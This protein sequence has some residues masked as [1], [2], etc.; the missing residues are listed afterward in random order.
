MEWV[1]YILIFLFIFLLAVFFLVL[2]LAFTFKEIRRYRIKKVKYG[3][4]PQVRYGLFGRWYYIYADISKGY[5]EIAKNIRELDKFRYAYTN[6]ECC[7]N[8]I[9]AH[10]R[11]KDAEYLALGNTVRGNK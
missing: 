11:L 9:K 4:N 6:E 2:N 10:Q 8:I 7:K 5:C 1:V 3:F